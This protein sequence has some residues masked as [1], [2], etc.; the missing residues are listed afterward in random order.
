MHFWSVTGLS[1]MVLALSAACLLFITI[2]NH[3]YLFQAV[4]AAVV[5]ALLFGVR[6]DMRNTAPDGC[7]WLIYGHIHDS[8]TCAAYHF[9]KEN[10]PCALNACFEINDH[11]ATQEELI[12]DNRKWCGR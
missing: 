2:C 9:I 8:T 4:L 5:V 3:W 10:L 11:L 6:A 12:E 1:C 7:P